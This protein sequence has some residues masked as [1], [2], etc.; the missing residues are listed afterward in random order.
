MANTS[1]LKRCCWVPARDLV[2]LDRHANGW[3]ARE[4][5][6]AGVPVCY[7]TQDPRDGTLWARWIMVISPN[8]PA[9]VTTV[10]PGQTF[11]S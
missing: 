10:P 1:G 9:R 11:F 8:C 6:H 4:I 5:A 7:A 3:Q 2:I